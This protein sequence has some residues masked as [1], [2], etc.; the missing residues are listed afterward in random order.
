[1]SQI[2]NEKTVSDSGEI[3][4]QDRRMLELVALA[5]TVS[6]SKATVLIQGESGTGKELFA[7]LIHRNSSR[8]HR[9]FVAINCA[10]I[11]ENLLESELFGYERGAFTGAMNAKAGKFELANGGTLLLDEISEMDVRL[12]AK[13]LR[14]LQ[15]GEVDR[16][17]GRKPMPVDVRIL[18]TTNRNLA[19]CV[20]QG[21]FRED[22]F[23]RLNVINVMVPPLRDRI[24]DIRLLAKHYV[25]LFAQRNQKSGL[26]ISEASCQHLEGYNWP[27]NVRELENVIERAVI[28]VTDQE[29]R[30]EQLQIEVRAVQSF[31]SGDS[32]AQAANAWIP[33]STLDDIERSVILE[34][35]H[36]HKGNRTHTAKALGISIRT[37]RNKIADYRKMGIFV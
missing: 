1:M 24:G 32:S 25:D 26:Q 19:D 33:G 9:P 36:Y 17:G 12:Q 35:L 28:T 13:I 4:T 21:T 34:A 8:S 31:S 16:I 5:K 27:G 22:L 15:E 10:A 23:Y 20:K 37:L 2:K 7:H 14:V 6:Q 3:I 30:P 29:I 18:A 11:P